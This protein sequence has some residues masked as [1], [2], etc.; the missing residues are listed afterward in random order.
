MVSA[1]RTADGTAEASVDVDEVFA[2][3]LAAEKAADDDLRSRD[4]DWTI[5]R[6]GVLTME[7]GT[8][9]V[10]LAESTGRGKVPREDVAAVLLALLNEP[11]TAG[12]TLELVAGDTPI[13][14]AVRAVAG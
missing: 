13:A 4:L 1:M 12:L 6:P 11:R 2:A 3:Y 14:D 5:L 7:S 8:G 10:R 9:H